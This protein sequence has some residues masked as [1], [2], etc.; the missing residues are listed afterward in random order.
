MTVWYKTDRQKRTNLKKTTRFCLF[1]F[2]YEMTVKHP[3]LSTHAPRRSIYK[4]QFLALAALDSRSYGSST[5]VA[6]L[7]HEP[8][9]DCLIFIILAM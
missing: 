9:D 8:G 5:N 6:L 3:N 7:L 1:C 2:I 4:K